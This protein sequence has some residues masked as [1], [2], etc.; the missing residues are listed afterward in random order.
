MSV[1]AEKVEEAIAQGDIDR[2]IKYAYGD[3]CRCQKIKGEPMCVCGMYG[4]ALREKIA[5]RALFQNK[6]ERIST[7]R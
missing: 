4:A 2:L 1:Y 7:A 5:P 6:I 3:T